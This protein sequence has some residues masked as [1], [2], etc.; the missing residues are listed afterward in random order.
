M[1]MAVAKVNTECELRVLH[2]GRMGSGWVRCLF[3]RLFNDAYL[4]CIA[5]N[6]KIVMSDELGRMVKGKDMPYLMA[7]LY[8]DKSLLG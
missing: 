2:H 1:L 4:R 6:F 3:L 5:S 8:Q 7:K